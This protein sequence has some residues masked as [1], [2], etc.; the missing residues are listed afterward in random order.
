MRQFRL[1]MVGISSAL[2]I[3]NLFFIDYQNLISKTNLSAFLG[4]I[5]ML[6]II[7]AMILSN[8]QEAKNKNIKS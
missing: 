8:R 5:A 7:L 6:F 4:I 3:L 1:I 2:I